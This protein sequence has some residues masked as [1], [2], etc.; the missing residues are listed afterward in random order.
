ML[1]S[2]FIITISILPDEHSMN[3]NDQDINGQQSVGTDIES[4]NQS[5]DGLTVNESV[6]EREESVV[7]YGYRLVLITNGN[8]VLCFR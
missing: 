8:S 4:L 2:Q 7:R 1:P 5:L 3:R 6:K